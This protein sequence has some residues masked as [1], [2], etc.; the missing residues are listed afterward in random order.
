[1][2]LD[3]AP[4]SPEL[5]DFLRN[6]R[7]CED[8]F[9]DLVDRLVATV[10]GPSLAAALSNAISSGPAGDWPCVLQLVGM[11]VGEHEELWN[12]LIEAV[13]RRQDLHW[14]DLMQAVAL[15]KIHARL[16]ESGTA[17][18]LAEDW[19]E[20]TAM[21]H[22]DLETLLQILEDDPENAPGWLGGI[23]KWPADERKQLRNRLNDRPAGRG[24]DTL[25]AWLDA[26]ESALT[27]EF[28][29]EVASTD[30][31]SE[32]QSR[33]IVTTDTV[34]LWA[35]DLLPDGTFGVGFE[36]PIDIP[37]RYVIAG[38]IKK[39]VR[40]TESFQSTDQDSFVPRLPAG[41]RVSFHP[42]YVRQVLRELIDTG[43]MPAA[44]TE[45]SL[46]ILETVRGELTDRH[47]SDSVAWDRWTTTLVDANPL[48]RRTLAMTAD[49]ERTLDEL[50]HWL[51]V[52]AEA[53]ELASEFRSSIDKTQA[54]RLRSAMRVWFERSLGP[55]MAVVIDHLR[56]M[57]YFWLSL[58][59]LAPENERSR[60]FEAARASARIVADLA[61]PS[62]VV[63]NQPFVEIWMK[64]VFGKARE[65]V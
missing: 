54:D 31:D 37:R 19:A 26:F 35:T 20:E 60:W 46:A 44:T 53:F 16:P 13:E 25:I 1:M 12:V 40:F 32:S 5:D 65:M 29:P 52:D 57:G 24:R 14:P 18:E 8:A 49:A 38:S 7:G 41:R 62:R 15:L 11:L 48:D 51:I 50:D 63:A 47:A 22:A 56:L 6:C 61:D 27:N 59:D 9:D 64:R 17:A 58:A 30:T 2:N 34:S 39:G 4:P 55:R 42:V 10:P 28:G 33:A 21:E 23:A 3:D 43:L 45:R 36:S